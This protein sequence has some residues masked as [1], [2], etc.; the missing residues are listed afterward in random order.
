MDM[1]IY[2]ALTRIAT[3][4]EFANC[5]NLMKELYSVGYYD[6]KTYQEKLLDFHKAYSKQLKAEE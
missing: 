2:N 6:D 3:D 5:L 4:I 1:M